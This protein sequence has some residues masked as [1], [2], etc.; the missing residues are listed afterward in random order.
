MPANQMLP[1][2]VECT[3]GSIGY[4]GEPECCGHGIDRGSHEECCGSPK[5]PAAH[6]VATTS[7]EYAPQ[8]VTAINCHDDLLAVAEMVDAW[9]NGLRH[10]TA[11]ES[12]MVKAARAA[13]AKGS[14]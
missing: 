9:G 2:P 7:V 10:E 14:R 6:E 5:Y 12:R 1:T 8:I 13:L 3:G 4:W 11:H